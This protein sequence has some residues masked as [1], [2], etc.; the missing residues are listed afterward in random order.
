ML[1]KFFNGTLV[2]SHMYNDVH[3]Y[4]LYQKNYGKVQSNLNG[5]RK[6]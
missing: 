2:S 1:N 6:E 5:N 4:Y 3:I